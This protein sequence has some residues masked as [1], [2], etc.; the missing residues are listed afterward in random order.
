MRARAEE[1]LQLWN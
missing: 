1:N